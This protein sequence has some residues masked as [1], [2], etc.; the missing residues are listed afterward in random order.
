MR[1]DRLKSGFTLIE[2]LVVISIIAILASILFPVFARVRENARRSSCQSNLKQ[3]G[4]GL[5]QYVGDYDDQMPRSFF[6]ANPQ[7]TKIDN[8]KWMDAIQ[9]YAKSEQVFVCPSDAGAKYRWSGNLAAGEKSENYGSYGQ[10]GAYSAAN[11]AQTPPRSAGAYLI[12]MAEISQPAQTMWA[13]D[14]NN[15]FEANG[16]FGIG[17]GNWLRAVNNPTIKTNA[18]EPRIPAG[19]RQLDTIIDRHL[20]TTNVLF[21]DGHVKA[22][23]LETLAQTR[24]VGGVAVM[25]M[26]TIEED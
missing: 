2:L 14:T 5:L 1:K 11:D 15:R 19:S 6:G 25:P 3:I 26:F 17:G 21:C 8:Y 23:K 7:A 24:T 12:S 20:G 10:N 22:M 13:A 9:P 18:D 16:N 4:L